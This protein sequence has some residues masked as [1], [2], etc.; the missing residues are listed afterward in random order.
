MKVSLK[1]LGLAYRRVKADLYYARYASAFKLLAYEKNL[2]ANLTNLKRILEREEF[3]TLDS[4]CSGHRIIPKGVEL[5]GENDAL[6]VFARTEEIQSIKQCDLRLVEDVPIDFHIVTQLWIDRLGGRLE[7]CF[8]D[9]SYGNRLRTHKGKPNVSYPGSFK[10]YLPQYQ[11]WHDGSLAKIEGVLRANREVVVMTADFTAFYHNLTPD[12]LLKDEFWSVLGLKDLSLSDI[13]L[14]KCVVLMLKKWGA[15]TPLGKGLPVGCSI[16]PVIANAALTLLDRKIERL[17]GY[18]HYGRYVDDIILVVDRPK[19][20]TKGQAGKKQFYKWL[21]G[22]ISAIHISEKE[23]LCYRE[24]MLSLADE[25]L[26]FKNS[27]T[28]VFVLGGDIGL[29]FVKSLREQIRKRSSEWRLMPDLPAAPR[30]FYDTFVSITNAQGNEVNKLREAEQITLRRAAFSAKLADFAAYMDCLNADDW[31]AQRIAFLSAIEKYFVTP[32]YF[33]DLATYFPRIVAIG[34]VGVKDAASKELAVIYE[35][36]KKIANLLQRAEKVKVT[37]ASNPVVDVQKRA[38][39]WKLLRDYQ[40]KSFTE[41]IATAISDDDLRQSIAGEIR[42][43]FQGDQPDDEQLPTYDALL[44]AD[45]AQCSYLRVLST[46]YDA[47]PIALRY[48]HHSMIGLEKILGPSIHETIIRLLKRRKEWSGILAAYAYG[49]LAF[50]VRPLRPMDLYALLPTPY[51]KGGKSRDV[52]LRWM[53]LLSYGDKAKEFLCFNRENSKPFLL[54]VPNRGSHKLSKKQISDSCPKVALAYW[55]IDD[56]TY[57]GQLTGSFCSGARASSFSRLMRL[58][59]KMHKS[60]KHIDYIVFPELAMPW[61]WYNYVSRRLKTVGISIISGVEYL[62]GQGNRV[63]NEVWCSLGYT[64][65]GFP[66]SVLVRVLKTAP[67]WHEADE[68]TRH[69]KVMRTAQKNGEFQAGD[70]VAH[71]TDSSGVFFSVLICSDLTDVTLRS[72]LRGKIDMLFVPA[73]NT[74]VE[75][76]DGIVQASALDLHAYV[77]LCNNGSI[78][79]T[80]IRAPYKDR[81]KRDVLRLRGG[82]DDYF[83]IGTVKVG[84]LRRSQAELIGW[85]DPKFKPRPIGFEMS[86]ER[87]AATVRKLNVEESYKFIK[88]G[89]KRFEVWWKNPTTAEPI[90]VGLRVGF[91]SL[92]TNGQILEYIRKSLL[93]CQYLP[94]EG[95]KEFIQACN[96][97][98]H[99][100]I[101]LDDKDGVVCLMAE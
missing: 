83:V 43:I 1:E 36:L 19:C 65:L 2:L 99:T 88:V 35:I 34:A 73:W 3:E 51:A 69:G 40:I 27:K 91:D 79:D 20:V 66:D 80:R 61:R 31:N 5:D 75:T 87:R 13:T 94:R 15:S 55:H 45:L 30:S 85:K 29:G 18:I 8:S 50:P 60:D 41:A 81:N 74:D 89:D 70:V 9:N 10:Y 12:F 98:L 32:R 97:Y 52:I 17:A 90:D 4:C 24:P 56:T 33:F 57:E 6:K 77:V 26:L 14:T 38:R 46:V 25:G 86:E 44:L 47:K 78:G 72:K 101:R 84:A 49:G 76:F 82:D 22:E 48:A 11:E 21:S 68:L 64:G 93:P 54:R 58:I 92:K 59:E 71:G 28:K 39:V 100:R 63:S 67:A 95:V 37:L 42:R 53:Q 96:T 16:S 7:E 23:D 62:H